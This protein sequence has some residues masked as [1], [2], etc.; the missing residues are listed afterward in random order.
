MESK[1]KYKCPDFIQIK[2]R[3]SA[4][5]ETIN[6]EE[7]FSGSSLPSAQNGS[8]D[9]TDNLFAPDGDGEFYLEDGCTLNGKEQGVDPRVWVQSFPLFPLSVLREVKNTKVTKWKKKCNHFQLNEK[10]EWRIKKL[11]N[12]R[13]S[14]SSSLTSSPVAS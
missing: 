13:L 3:M 10:D 1:V 5:A 6:V 4:A 12:K 9:G 7:K 14:L 2:Q 11:I 8:P